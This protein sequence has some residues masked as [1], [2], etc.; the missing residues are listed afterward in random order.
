MGR[1]RGPLL[2]RRQPGRDPLRAPSRQ[3]CAWPPATSTPAAPSLRRLVRAEPLP[4]L[5][6]LRLA[7]P[8]RG[9]VRQLGRP[10][11]TADT[12]AGT[13]VALSV[14]T[15]N[16]PT[17]DGSWSGFNPVGSSGGSIGGSSRYLQ[18]RAQLSSSDQDKTPTLSDVSR[19]LRGRHDRP[20]H[21]DRLRAH[22][23]ASN[24]SPSFGFSADEPGSSFECRLDSAQAADWAACSSPKSY[25][26][27]PDGTHTFEVRATDGAG[28]TDPTPASRS[29]TIDTGAPDTQIDSG[30]TGT[31]SNPSPSFGFS[32]DEPGS[33][34]ECRLDSAQAADWAACS[35]PKS[36]TNLARRQPH[37]RGQSHRRGRKH[38]PDPGLPE[39]HDRLRRPRPLRSPAPTPIPGQ[40]QQPADQGHRRARL[41]REALHDG[42]LHRLARGVRARE[43]VRLPGPRRHGRGQH[44][45]AVPRHRHR[46][47]GQRLAVLA[48]PQL[49]R[50]LDP[51]PGSQ[52]TGTDPETPANKNHPRIKGTAE[53][54]ST[55]RLYKT[56]DCTGAP[57]GSGSASK[58]ASPG[59]PPPSRTTRPPRSAPPPP[60]RAG[61]A[62]PCSAERTYVEDSTEPQTTIT[63]G[64]SGN[65][66]DDTPTFEF[67]SSESGSTFACRFDPSRSTPAPARTPATLRQG[68]SLSARIPS[69]SRRRI[70]QG[71]PIRR[72]PSASSPSP[73]SAAGA[74]MDTRRPSPPPPRRS[75]PRMCCT[76]GGLGRR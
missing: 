16:T 8:R 53:A 17:P 49:H 46:R 5:G 1:D 41:D 9:P 51:A 14:R 61:N 15:G 67:Q 34:F 6:H 64:P 21:P 23:D 30:P 31:T 7:G 72:Q 4:G 40:Q 57:G 59:S 27:L 36:Y 47:R 65:T 25:T 54:N 29:F 55:V 18:Y 62:S 35:S 63:S 56:A 32:A 76:P 13:G 28:N 22:R 12:P 70:R 66:T 43:R 68:R 37:L 75:R 48:G 3:P 24:P 26:N 69:R 50:G 38:R 73:H 74:I 20:R 19:E 33:S 39:L 45:H 42:R 10:L 2:R 71:T 52:I 11:W 58:F 60:M 44:D